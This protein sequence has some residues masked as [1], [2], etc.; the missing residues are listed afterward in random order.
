M[1][2]F[3]WERSRALILTLC[4]M[5]VIAKAKTN[6]VVPASV[7]R[8]AGIKPGDRLEFKVSGGIINIVPKLPTAD[9]EYTPQQRK[10]IDAELAEGLADLKAGRV[11]GPFKN[12]AEIA[13]FLKKQLRSKPAKKSQDFVK[14]TKK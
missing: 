7:R 14:K 3:L 6:L 12:G 8:Q 10:I 11:V 13:S 2:C 9:G 5:T 1:L 4:F